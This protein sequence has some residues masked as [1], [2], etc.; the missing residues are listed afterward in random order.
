MEPARKWLDPPQAEP[1][2]SE[3]E[4]QK[5]QRVEW[6]TKVGKTIFYI[7]VAAAIWFFYW[8]NGIPCPC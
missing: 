1:S 2:P 4:L 5:A 8:L 7:T 3:T 6:E